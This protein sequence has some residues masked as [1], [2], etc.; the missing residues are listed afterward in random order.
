MQRAGESEKEGIKV[1]TEVKVFENKREAE[2]AEANSEL[3]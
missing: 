1:K 2:V 3:A